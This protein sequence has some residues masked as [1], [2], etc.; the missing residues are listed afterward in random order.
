MAQNFL[1]GQKALLK[2]DKKLLEF[3]INPRKEFAKGYIIDNF[4]IIN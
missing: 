2:S 3:I 1:L 4:K